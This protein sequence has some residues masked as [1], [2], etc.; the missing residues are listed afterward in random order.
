M[1]SVSYDFGYLTEGIEQFESFLLSKNLFWPISSAPPYGEPAYPRLTIGGFL[2]SNNRLRARDL[3]L[4]QEKILHSLQMKIDNF[5][6][7]WRSAWENKAHSELKSRFRQWDQYVNELQI[8]PEENIPYYRSE[9]RVRVLI[10]LLLPEIGSTEN[11]YWD[12]L[13]GLDSLLKSI[14]TAGTFVWDEEISSGFDEDQYW[15][16]WGFPEVVRFQF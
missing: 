10:E 3:D 16:L 9:V 15:Y 13:T 14:F 4:S 1:P 11:Y 5:R 6:K 7:R 12:Q 8:N 2:L